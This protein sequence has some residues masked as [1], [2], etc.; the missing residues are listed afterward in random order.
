MSTAATTHFAPAIDTAAPRRFHA[1]MA[2][3]CAAVAFARE[4]GAA[5]VEG[6]PI[7]DPTGAPITWGENSVGSVQA[8]RAAGFVE[9]A[10]PTTRRRVMRV[11]LRR[12]AR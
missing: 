7:V 8:F 4:R 10:R 9:V 3:V 11:D 12:G 5:A 1:R 6:Y 2:A